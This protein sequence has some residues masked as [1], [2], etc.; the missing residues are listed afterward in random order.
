MAWPNPFRRKDENT[1]TCWDYTFQLT[2]DHLTVEDSHPLKFS[3]DKLGE[4]CLNILNEIDPPSKAEH[5]VPKT[6]AQISEKL[7]ISKPKRDLFKSLETHVDEHPKLGELW[8]Q[9]NTVPTWVDWDQ[10]WKPSALSC[11]HC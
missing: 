5:V 2:E 8:V 6:E 3:Y 4:E 7:R 10:V 11:S 9:L 1:K